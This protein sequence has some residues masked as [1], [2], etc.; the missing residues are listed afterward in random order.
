[1]ADNERGNKD[2]S[3]GV[4][5]Q[6]RHHEAHVL[7]GN[8]TEPQPTTPMFCKSEH[9]GVKSQRKSSLDKI[10]LAGCA[11]RRSLT[12]AHNFL[13]T[14]AFKECFEHFDMNDV[15]KITYLIAVYVCSTTFYHHVYCSRIQPLM[16]GSSFITP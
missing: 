13:Q 9:I 2:S 1:M 16:R 3:R 4:V 12:A 6:V 15:N 8:C 7:F 11:L 10:S 14:L 5:A